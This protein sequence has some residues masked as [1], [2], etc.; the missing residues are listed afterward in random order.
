MTV[1]PLE[2][3]F[4]GSEGFGKASGEWCAAIEIDLAER[5]E[6]VPGG[7]AGADVGEGELHGGRIP[8][9]DGDCRTEG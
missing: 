7:G 3:S 9:G 1:E 6:I 2:D 8:E 5:V 4:L